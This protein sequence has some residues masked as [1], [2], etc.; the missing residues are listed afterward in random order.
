VVGERDGW[1]VGWTGVMGGGSGLA[2]E[3]DGCLLYVFLQLLHVPLELGPSVLEPADDLKQNRFI[4]IITLFLDNAALFLYCLTLVKLS[5][6]MT[7]SDHC[8]KGANTK[9]LPQLFI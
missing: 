7:L 5:T 2:R 3:G 1:E 9:M 6:G 8:R 4:I